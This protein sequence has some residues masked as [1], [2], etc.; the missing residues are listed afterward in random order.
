ME[1]TEKVYLE[2]TLNVIFTQISHD[3]IRNNFSYCSPYE[4]TFHTE[5]VALNEIYAFL[6]C[7]NFS[8]DDPFLRNLMKIQ[9]EKT[10]T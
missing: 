6:T 9:V 8:Y 3:L 2:A 5:I 10:S 4:K 1:T 7:N